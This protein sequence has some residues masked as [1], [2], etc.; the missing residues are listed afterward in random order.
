MHDSSTS[1]QSSEKLLNE[2]NSN[3]DFG[4][5]QLKL[6]TMSFEFI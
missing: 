3:I 6:I 2:R 5:I 4:K 1:W